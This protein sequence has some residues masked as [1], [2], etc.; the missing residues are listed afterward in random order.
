MPSERQNRIPHVELELCDGAIHLTRPAL[1]CVIILVPRGAVKKCSGHRYY[2]FV[3]YADCTRT[4][5]S[6]LILTSTLFLRACFWT[7]LS[8]LISASLKRT[9][10][11]LRTSGF[12]AFAIYFMLTNNTYTVPHPMTP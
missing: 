10:M 6:A 9:D 5:T 12:F 11:R 2:F 3:M 1:E 7:A 8:A 4:R